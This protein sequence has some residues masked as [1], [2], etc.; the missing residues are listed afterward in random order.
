MSAPDRGPRGLVSPDEEREDPLRE[1]DGSTTGV[2]G[3]TLRLCNP[4]VSRPSG[5]SWGHA[6]CYN[7]SRVAVA[8]RDDPFLGAIA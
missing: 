3:S 8:R 5:L 1:P 7:G 2:T 4:P 6:S